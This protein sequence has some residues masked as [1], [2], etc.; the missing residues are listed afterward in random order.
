MRHCLAVHDASALEFVNHEHFH[1]SLLLIDLKNFYEV[2]KNRS[3]EKKEKKHKG[4]E[5]WKILL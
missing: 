3:Y 2:A 4:Q 5:G 1:G